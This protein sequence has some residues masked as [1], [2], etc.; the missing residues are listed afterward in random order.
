MATG[1]NSASDVIAFKE[2]DTGG[3]KVG[4]GGS[5]YNSGDISNSSKIDFQPYNKAY[6][7]DL[8]VNTGDHVDQTTGNH[9]DQ[10]SSSGY[11]SSTVNANTS[12]TQTNSLTANTHQYVSAG[13][14]GNGGSYDS[15]KG[16]DVS[17]TQLHMDTDSQSNAINDSDQ[18]HISDYVH[19]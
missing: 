5:G 12:V 9:S 14:G 11:D 1:F 15:A 13:N 4:N 6:G 10:S 8:T 16:G 3:Q 17:F 19:G 18:F 2:I 7:A